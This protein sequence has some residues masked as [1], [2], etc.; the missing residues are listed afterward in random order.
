MNT[1]EYGENKTWF[2]SNAG[3]IG[4][5][6]LAGT[7]I[8]LDVALPQTLSTAVDR[9]LEHPKMKY[10]AYAAGGLVAGHL[11]NVIPPKVDPIERVAGYVA[12]KLNL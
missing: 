7:V 9:A 11:F 5:G 12:R 4:W 10:V 1:L 3:T 8:A 2:E 6:V